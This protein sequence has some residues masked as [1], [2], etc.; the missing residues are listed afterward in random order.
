MTIAKKK[1]KFKKVGIGISIILAITFIVFSFFIIKVDILPIKY[2]IPF[3][4]LLLGIIGFNIYIL[5]NNKFKLWLKYFSS[6]I[7]IIISIIFIIGSLYINK[8]YNFMDNIGNNNTIKEKYYV[9]V[10]KE[11]KY[12]SI[13]DLK[14][15]DIYT[16]NE[17]IEIY[18][19][20]IKELNK[21]Q[22]K[23]IES[24]SVNTM[25]DNLIKSKIEAIL[26]SAAHK[27]AIRESI[28]N[29]DE[30]TKIIHTIEVSVEVE[31]KEQKEIDI[32]DESFTIYLSGSDSYGHIEERSRSDVNMLI[33]IN[34]NTH[35]VLLTSIPRDYYVQLSGTTGYKDKLTHA[36]MYGVD[37]SIK[38]I[39]EFMDIEIDY[40]VKVNFSTLVQVVD[41][42]GGI[43]VYSDKGFRPWTDGSIYIP[44][45]NVHMNGKMA[46]AFARERYTY[47]EGDRHR[48]QNQQDVLTAII[49]KVSNSTVL[50]TKYTTFLEQLSSSFETN[51]KTEDITE[52]IK[53]QINKMPSWNINKY[54]L[55]GSDSSGYTYS[56]GKQNLYVM[57]PKVDTI[58]EGKRRIDLI[59]EGKKITE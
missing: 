12:K 3:I 6:F 58:V 1:K 23:L 54:S 37:M 59:I 55:D 14:D 10:N 17:G 24:D 33:T 41:I 49:N 56:F 39:E 46:I 4:I 16:F 11:S 35:E 36:G 45:G 53:L 48:V 26:I 8:T 15:K 29:F 25:S 22:V 20:A 5:I 42:I 2:L 21:E 27:E 38:T 13:K 47:L 31:K 40:Y 57:E 19:K 44:K 52:L 30:V 34:P 9:V 51:I 7:S 18:T 50:L 28:T 43:D 32:S